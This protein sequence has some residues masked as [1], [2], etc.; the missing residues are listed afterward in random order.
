MKIKNKKFVIEFIGDKKLKIF[1][2]ASKNRL[3][4]MSQYFQTLHRNPEPTAITIKIVSNDEIKEM[5][6]QFRKKNK[7]TD[8]LSFPDEKDAGDIAI[9][10]SYILNKQNK[11]SAQNFFMLVGHGILH[12]FGYTHYEKQT[13]KNMRFLENTLMLHLG[14]KVVHEN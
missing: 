7:V 14:L 10:E 4:K 6:R 13:R 12:L 5:N 9:A 3:N 8:V 2:T 11:I 1:L